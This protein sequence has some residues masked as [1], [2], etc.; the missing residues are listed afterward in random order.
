M[1][2][3]QTGVYT[4]ETINAIDFIA[5]GKLIGKLFKKEKTQLLLSILKNI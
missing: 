3:N 2:A 5:V 1:R 4:G